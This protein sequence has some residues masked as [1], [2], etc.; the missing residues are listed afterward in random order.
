MSAVAGV[1]SID[2]KIDLFVRG[3]RA[4]ATNELREYAVRR[5]SFAVSRFRHRIR[6][7][8][9]R[10]VDENGPRRGVDSRCS[11]EANLV[12]GGPLFV[13]AT[14]AWQTMRA[15]SRSAR[16]YVRHVKATFAGLKTD[17]A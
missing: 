2:T 11:I 15:L 12:D 7:L 10:L 4:E 9:V 5:L 6:D 17:R 14:A 3:E 1:D 16:D 13:E 8:R